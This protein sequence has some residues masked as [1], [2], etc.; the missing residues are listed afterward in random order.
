MKDILWYYQEFC[1]VNSFY[2]YKQELFRPE[3]KDRRQISKIFK[4]ANIELTKIDKYICSP[5][6][7]VEKARGKLR[8]KT[9]THTAKT[10][11]MILWILKVND[12]YDL[13]DFAPIVVDFRFHNR[14]KR[15]HKDY[16][17]IL[18]VAQ[19]DGFVE[20]A[21]IPY[22]V[23]Q[24]V[25]TSFDLDDL[26]VEECINKVREA[27]AKQPIYNKLFWR[28]WTPKAHEIKHP[29]NK[30]LKEGSKNDHLLFDIKASDWQQGS[31]SKNFVHFLDYPKYKYHID[32][33]GLHH[34]HCGRRFWLYHMNRVLFIPE[35]D[36]HKLFFEVWENPPKAY[37]HFIPF[38]LR[39]MSD[40]GEK[41]KWLEDNP[42]EYER[43]RN[44]CFEYSKNR[45]NHHELET[46]I[47]SKLEG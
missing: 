7:T 29:R 24:P 23:S 27:G 14:A 13:K 41:V 8:I 5:G 1:K 16:E 31:G 25:A 19:K 4:E 20:E 17:R 22:Y 6:F 34:G 9:T 3:L 30:L 45:M 32:C 26:S 10:I 44:N 11:G 46:F 37:E 15:R 47:K 42:K 38:S 18:G 2:K 40:L 39:N 28:G 43:I 35:D 12:K 21:F 33:P 36:Q